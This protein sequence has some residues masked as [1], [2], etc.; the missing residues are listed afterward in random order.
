MGDNL[1]LSIGVGGSGLGQDRDFGTARSFIPRN[2]PEIFNRGSRLWTSQ[3]WDSRAEVVDGE[4]LNPAGDHLP[5]GLDSIL[6]VQAMFPV[7]SRDELR[8][9]LGENELG[10]VDDDDFQGIWDGLMNRLLA[11]PE[12]EVLFQEA[13]PEKSVEELGFEDA[14]NAIAAFESEAFTFFDSP[15]DRY[16]AGD[17]EALD[18]QAK[19]GALVFFG[20]GKCSQCHSGPLLTDQQH[21]NMGTPQLGPGKE[22]EAPEDF[23]RFRVTGDP[24]DLYHFRTPPLRNVEFT[25]PYMHDGAFTSLEG[26]VR[27]HL[28]TIDSFEN[29]DESQLDPRLQDQVLSDSEISSTLDPFQKGRT[30]LKEDEIEDLLAFLRSLTSESVFEASVFGTGP[31]AETIPAAVPSGLPVDRVPD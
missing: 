17:S 16:L 12:Y 11:I 14:A 26:A 30:P 10:A 4:F 23:G 8:G 25:G 20:K 7:T 15:F 21:H 31:L 19:R 28:E 24:K 5:D 18:D 2:A 27:H 6:A 22:G 29:Y 3:F 9:H 1:S 13:Y